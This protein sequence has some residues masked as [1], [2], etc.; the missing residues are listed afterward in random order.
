[1]KVVKNK[2]AP[3]SQKGPKLVAQTEFCVYIVLDEGFS[4]KFSKRLLT[5]FVSKAFSKA[6]NIHFFN[7]CV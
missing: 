5:G 1:M 7:G 3:T 2:L 4:A 6:A